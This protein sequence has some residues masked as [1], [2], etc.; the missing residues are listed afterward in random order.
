MTPTLQREIDK[1]LSKKNPYYSRFSKELIDFLEENYPTLPTTKA[2]W[3][4]YKDG[5]TVHDIPKCGLDGCNNN[6]KWNVKLNK[7]DTGCC[8]NHIKIITHY[9][10][11]VINISKIIIN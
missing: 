4:L 9:N 11:L 2:R 3:T 5:L 6:V 8:T 7:F 1:Y 10:Y